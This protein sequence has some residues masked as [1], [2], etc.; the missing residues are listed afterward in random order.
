MKKDNVQALEAE[1]KRLREENVQLRVAK[2]GMNPLYREMIDHLIAG[3]K[4]IS[5]LAELMMRDNRAISQWLHQIKMRYEAEIIT[6]SN[7]EKQ[8]AN[9]QFFVEIEQQGEVSTKQVD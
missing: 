8:L 5:Q 9:A 7:G 6:L 2:R 3:P 4:T 1:V